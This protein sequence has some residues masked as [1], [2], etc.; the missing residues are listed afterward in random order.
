MFKNARA[1]SFIVTGLAAL[2]V[3]SGIALVWVSGAS[4]E[5]IPVFVDERAIYSG[6][7]EENVSLMF[8]VYSGSEYIPDIL[9]TLEKHNVKATFFIGGCWADKNEELLKQIYAEGHEIGSHG[10]LHRD[11]SAMNYASNYEEMQVADKLIS[12]I[13]DDEIRLFAPPSGAY[14]EYTLD[15]AEAMGYKTILWSKDTIDWRDQDTELIIN[16][17][18]NELKGGDLILMHPTKCTAEALDTVLT[19]I[20]ENNLKQSIVSQTL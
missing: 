9:D 18:T 15:A 17:A 13:T 20:S 14:N 6:S 7:S 5:D 1:F 8:N 4:G 11:H 16:R 2:A 12:A 10:Y 19:K 3:I